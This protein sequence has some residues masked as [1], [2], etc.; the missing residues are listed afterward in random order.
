MN[1]KIVYGKDNRQN[2][3]GIELGE[4]DVEI[5]FADGTLKVE[6]FDRYIIYKRPEIKGLTGKLKGEQ[7]YKYFRKFKSKR[8]YWDGYKSAPFPSVYVPKSDELM[9]MLK[10]GTTMYKGMRYE[11]LTI[12]SIDIETNGLK[13]DKESLVYLISV[14]YRNKSGIV[15]KLFSL[16]EYKDQQEMIEDFCQMVIDLDPHVIAGHNV[17]GFDLR[18][19][20]HCYGKPLTIGK[21]GRKG[22]ISGKSRLFRKDGHKQYEYQNYTIPGR[23][24]VD[25]FYLAMKYDFKNKYNSYGLKSIIEQ[26]G[27]VKTGRQFYDAATIKD[28]WQKPAEREKI[29]EYCKDDSLDA[30]AL[31]DIMLPTYFYYVQILPMGLQEAILSASGSQVNA[32]MVRSY[33]QDGYS[34]PESTGR[35]DYEGA[36]SFGNPGIYSHV[37]KVDVASLYP[38][39]ILEHKIYDKT[40]DPQAHFLEI[41]KILTAQRLENKQRAKETGDRY[42]SDMEQ[43]QKI[44]INSAYGFMGAPGL[45]FNSPVNAAKV[46]KM[47]RDILNRGLGWVNIKGYQVVNADTDSFSYSAGHKLSDKE[48]EKHIKEIN[49]LFPDQIVWE[50]DGR[51][52]QVVVV[53]AK[54]Y[55]LEDYNNK[56]TIKGSGLKASMKEPALKEFISEFINRLL[57]GHRELALKVMLYD[58]YAKEILNISDINRW[59][60]SKNIT[61]AV[62]TSDRT[63]EIKIREAIKGLGYKE[64]DRINVFFDI[65]DSLCL[66]SNYSGTY[67]IER[68]LEKLFKTVKVFENILDIKAFPNYKLKKNKKALEKLA[69]PSEGDNLPRAAV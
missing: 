65:D 42:Y 50:D 40:K 67:S 38:S 30:L 18:Y 37:N 7:P 64:G 36:I 21:E 16:D 32:I 25:T 68:L 5:Y 45:N 23:Q 10:T 11:N 51:Y 8:E 24:I 44:I 59:C 56:I 3:V 61:K 48:F 41:V 13:M 46:T 14:T 9:Y 58:N 69:T 62:L 52:K 55:V 63:N 54:N 35:A 49:L 66:N 53:K 15:S 12:M 29:K 17:I 47:G 34:L 39:I 20:Q 57:K 43:A 60:S 31:C 22:S 4:N 1:S 33:L 19:L 2:I 6:P 27:L 28:N 26:E